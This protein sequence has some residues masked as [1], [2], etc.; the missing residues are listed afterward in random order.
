[1]EEELQLLSLLELLGRGLYPRGRVNRRIWP[2]STNVM[3]SMTLL[4]I[5][6]VYLSPTKPF[7]PHLKNESSSQSSWLKDGL[8]YGV[9]SN[10]G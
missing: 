3:F 6:D 8:L 9:V 5:I 2:A 10:D 4:Y 7:G 1:M